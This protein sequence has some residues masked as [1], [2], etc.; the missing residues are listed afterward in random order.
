MALDFLT[1]RR[2]LFGLSAIFLVTFSLLFVT[3]IRTNF[4][5]HVLPSGTVLPNNLSSMSEETVSNC[6]L[7]EPFEV[8][9]PCEKCSSY[10]KKFLPNLCRISGYKDYVLCSK[11]NVKT[12]RSCPVPKD[13]QKKQF[14]IFE[15]I[16]F[17]IALLSIAS[18]QSRQRTL[19]KQMVEKIKRQIGENAE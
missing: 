16:V 3:H 18:V 12:Y 6:H 11:S 4:I 2:V 19:D 10:E 9:K 7:S 1:R 13:V 17:F 15:T 14:W 5:Q 8:L